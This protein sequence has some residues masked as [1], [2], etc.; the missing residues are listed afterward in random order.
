MLKEIQ[1]LLTRFSFNCDRITELRI[2]DCD[3]NS[4]KG[5]KTASKTLKTLFIHNLKSV[6][7]ART[8][9]SKYIYI[10]TA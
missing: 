8:I 9:I 1:Q 10:S 4:S 6:D 2:H 5:I 7:I 3:S